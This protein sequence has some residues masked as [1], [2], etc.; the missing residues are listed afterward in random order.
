MTEFEIQVLIAPYRAEVEAVAA[1]YILLGIPGSAETRKVWS[2]S[3][4]FISWRALADKISYEYEMP[5]W[6]YI[7]KKYGPFKSWKAP[8]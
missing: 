1:K 3:E 7:Y 6:L 4:P 5:L 8:K 2:V